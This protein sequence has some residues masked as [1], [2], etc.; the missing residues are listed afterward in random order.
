MNWARGAFRIWAV[1]TVTWL[2][3]VTWYIYGDSGRRIAELTNQITTLERG[4][5]NLQITVTRQED[6]PWAKYPNAGREDRRYI[7]L[8]IDW[9]PLGVGIPEGEARFVPLYCNLPDL[10]LNQIDLK[11]FDPDAY[12]ANKGQM[13][14]LRL[15]D[16]KVYVAQKLRDS[17]SVEVAEALWEFSLFGFLPPLGLLGSW[18]LGIWILRGFRP[19]T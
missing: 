8:S 2:G 15:D 13:Y 7:C 10:L 6:G 11:K 18:F 12:L 3:F 4:D 19:R 16:A 1:F 5:R 9:N 17:R 14:G